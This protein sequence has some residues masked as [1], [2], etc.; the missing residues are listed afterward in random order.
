MKKM[1]VVIIGLMLVSNISFGQKKFVPHVKGDKAVLFSFSGLSNLGA[2]SYQGGIGYKKFISPKT[3]LR[4]AVDIYNFNQK[5]SWGPEFYPTGYVGED[6]KYRE[7]RIL[8]DLAAEIHRNKGKVDPYYGGGFEF[9]FTRTKMIE[10]VQGP[11]GTALVATEV[12]NDLDGDAATRFEIY[13]LF[14]VEY[15]INSILT[16]AA[17]YHL[18]FNLVSQPDMKVTDPAGVE[19]SFTGG[20]YSYVSLGSVGFL[21][22]AIYLNR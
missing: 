21:T 20:S 10:S 11:Q 16:L 17:E 19:T 14:G 13:G 18:R 3:A 2:G 7:N 4:A 5:I 12:K 1:L 15:A 9:G 8:L 6:G 22:L